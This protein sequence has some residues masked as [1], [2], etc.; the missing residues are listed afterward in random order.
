MHSTH[1]ET[2]TH[3]DN[4]TVSEEDVC[5]FVSKG[6]VLEVVNESTD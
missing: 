6:S 3:I 2:Q 5:C 4:L 1:T